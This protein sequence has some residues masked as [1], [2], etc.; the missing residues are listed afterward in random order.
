MLYSSANLKMEKERK[1]LP[2][3]GLPSMKLVF[4]LNIFISQ[5]DTYI[6][7]NYNIINRIRTKAR[8]Y[9][10]HLLRHKYIVLH[11]WHLIFQT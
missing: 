7:N 2:Y 3:V 8:A 1:I 11:T 10:V 6:Y 5:I 4:G 9:L